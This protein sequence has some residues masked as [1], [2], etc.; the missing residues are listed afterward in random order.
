MTIAQEE[1]FGPVLSLIHFSKESDAI[2]IANGTR[3]GRAA[4]IFT[5]DAE[6]IRR[7]SRELEVGNVFVNRPIRISPGATWSGLCESGLNT[8]LGDGALSAFT[9]LRTI[10]TRTP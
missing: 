3:Y 7:L 9:R 1:V 6:R 4:A 5:C 2:S 10:D 8:A